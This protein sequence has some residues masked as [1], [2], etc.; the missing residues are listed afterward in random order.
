MVWVKLALF[1]KAEKFTKMKTSKSQ[2]SK[3]PSQGGLDLFDP[4]KASPD[5]IAQSIPWFDDVMASK[6]GYK[7]KLGTAV[8]GDSLELLAAIPTNSVNLVI[9]SPPYALH[10]KKAYGNAEKNNYVEWFLPFAK[11]IHRILAD[12]GSFVLNI[13]GSYNQGSPTKSLYQFHLLIAL[14]E[15]VGFHLAQDCFWYNPAKMPVPA[16][17]VTV[18]RIRIKDSVE[19]VWWLSKTQNPKASNR[20]VLKEY[21]PDMLRLAER[22]KI[23][24]QRPSGHVINESWKDT[25]AKGAIPSNVVESMDDEA[26]DSMLKM[27]N[28]SANDKYTLRCKEAGATIHPARFPAALPEFFIKLTTEPGDLVVDPFSGSNTTGSVCERLGR[29][30]KSFELNEEYVRGGIYRF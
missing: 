23:A 17:W 5:L 22:D 21:S 24:T 19:Y 20:R 13:G 18:R 10:F 11:E 30:W 15:Q 8:V 2:H 9:T 14:V 26:P 1:C 29:A 16:E 4:Q 12:D 25:T 7:T 6:P 28:N 27:G 3:N